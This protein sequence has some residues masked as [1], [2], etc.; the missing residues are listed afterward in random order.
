MGSP[1][2]RGWKLPCR[3]D[4]SALAAPRLV[5]PLPELGSKPAAKGALSQELL[6]LHPAEG[7]CC[8][9]LLSAT[10]E[11]SPNSAGLKDLT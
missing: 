5:R 4:R 11:W 2:R 10:R 7:T 3:Q 6:L 9:D 8:L 1:G